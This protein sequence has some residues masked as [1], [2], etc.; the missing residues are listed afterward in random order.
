M[1]LYSYMED[2]LFFVDIIFDVQICL[3]YLLT[4]I[5]L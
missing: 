3:V 1:T 4:C 2:I 5:S